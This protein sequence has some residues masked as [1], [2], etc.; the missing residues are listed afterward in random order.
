VLFDRTSSQRKISLFRIIAVL[1]DFCAFC[2]QV[3]AC[4]NFKPAH[5]FGMIRIAASLRDYRCFSLARASVC[6]L[7][8]IRNETA[9]GWTLGLRQR[10]PEAAGDR[11]AIFFSRRSLQQFAIVF[12]GVVNEFRSVS[13]GQ[14]NF[15]RSSI[16]DL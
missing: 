13:F 7:F 4:A 9:E 10:M 1:L 2:S 11:V 15:N 3:R 16:F 12:D 5:D 8:G 14:N 6:P